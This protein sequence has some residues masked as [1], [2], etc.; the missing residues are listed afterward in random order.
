MHVIIPA[1]DEQ[2]AI[3]GVVAALLAQGVAGVLVVDNGSRDATSAR[4]RAA[5]A[6]V[7]SEPEK[8]Y[9]AACLAGIAALGSLDDDAIIAF[10]D[11]DA[12]DDPRDLERLIAPLMNDEADL[13]IGSRTKG[14]RDAGALPVHAMFGNRFA[15]WLIRVRTG[16]LFSDL[17]PLRAI[18]YGNLKR[19]GME[20]RNFGW[21]VEMQLKA[22]RA[23]MRILEIPVR[24]RKRIGESKISGSFMGSV[25]AGTKILATVV[26]HG[27]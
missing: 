23:G 6:R 18:K 4:A 27:G 10:A 2:A 5:G 17:G 14:V 20:D 9:G 3:G 12:S 22:L 21:T 19:L 11:G 15:C 25:R 1:L 8:G 13:V 7:V 16:A 26:K 24:Y